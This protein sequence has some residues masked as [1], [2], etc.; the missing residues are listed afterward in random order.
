MDVQADAR[1]WAAAPGAQELSLAYV[2]EKKKTCVQPHWLVDC[3]VDWK[4]L[5]PLISHACMGMGRHVDDD[6]LEVN[7]EM[8]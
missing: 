5:L 6:L 4:C 3:I 8:K 7:E 1:R 2:R